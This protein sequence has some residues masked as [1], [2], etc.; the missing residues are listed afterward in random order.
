MRRSFGARDSARSVSPFPAH[1]RRSPCLPALRRSGRGG[2]SW[3]E[4]RPLS[5]TGE[6]SSDHGSGPSETR[7]RGG[8]VPETLAENHTVSTPGEP[9]P[10]EHFASARTDE[11]V[12]KIGELRLPLAGP[13]CPRARLYRYPDGR[14]LWVVRL[15]EYDHVVPHVVATHVLR[16]F[17]RIN[18]LP[19]VRAEIDALVERARAP[20]R[21]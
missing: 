17:A 16:E 18:R 4:R 21:P 15:W 12:R 19:L 14:L 11:R 10:D 7:G 3:E 9:V 20:G 13:Y 8:G 5:A 6:P 1:D 2:G